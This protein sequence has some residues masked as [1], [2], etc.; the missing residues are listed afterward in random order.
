MN[1]ILKLSIIIVVLMSFPAVA[2]A[3]NSENTLK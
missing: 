3:N 1:L 2:F